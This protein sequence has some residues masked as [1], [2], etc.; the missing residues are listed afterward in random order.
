MPWL[1]QYRA[2]PPWR[3]VVYV[4]CL[5]ALVALVVIDIAWKGAQ[6]TTIAVLA[7][8]VALI[9]LRPGGISGPR[10]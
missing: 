7:L 6:Y 2:L 8:L 1:D 4:V 3:L 10:N 5:L 9:L